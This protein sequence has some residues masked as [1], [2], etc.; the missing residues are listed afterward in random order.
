MLIKYCSI[1]LLGSFLSFSVWADELTYL[2]IA[3]QAAP[4]QINTSTHKSQSGII[5]DVITLLAA[6]KPLSISTQ[7]MPFKRYVHEIKQRTYPN[8]ISYGSPLWRAKGKHWS[9]NKRLSAQPL[10]K[11]NHQLVQR[12]DDLR[13]YSKIED[14]FGKTIIL[15]RGFDYPGLD[16]YIENSQIN[17][18]DFKSHQ[19]ALHALMSRRGDVFIEMESRISYAIKQHNIEKDD[20]LFTDISAITP[21]LYIHLSYGDAVSSELIDWID[22]QIIIMKATGQLEKIIRRYQ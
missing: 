18:I 4:F 17:K 6:K 8:W 9:Q 20:Y 1:L 16:A 2:V 14:L 19:S 3:N 22:D 13:S 7:V 11:V 10:F 21:S 15:L 12:S 5:S